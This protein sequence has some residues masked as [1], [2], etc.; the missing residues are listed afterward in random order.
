MKPIL[1]RYYVA[2]CVWDFRVEQGDSDVKIRPEKVNVDTDF[3]SIC[4]KYYIHLYLILDKNQNLTD[5]G[6]ADN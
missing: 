5:T 6:M 1:S 2:F 4:E 3:Y